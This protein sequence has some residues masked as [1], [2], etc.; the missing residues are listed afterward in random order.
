MCNGAATKLGGR[1]LEIVLFF[2]I[3]VLVYYSIQYIRLKGEI[4]SRSIKL[5]EEWKERE[6]KTI[7]ARYNEEI[8]RLKRLYVEELER[9]K[10][11]Y[12]ELA[13]RTAKNLF[14]TWKKKEEERIRKEAVEKSTSVIKGKVTEHLVPFFPEFKYNPKDVRF[15]GSPIDLVIFQGL[16]EGRL[17]KIIFAEVKTGKSNLTARERVIRD[18][19]EKKNVTFEVIEV[20][21]VPNKIQLK[22]LVPESGINNFSGDEQNSKFSF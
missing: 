2:L 3:L 6:L 19:I 12:S 16:S 22:Y 21:R 10:K 1:M 11:N 15:I 9:M 4:E 20:P 7:S 13:E 5:Y 8:E 18:C 14:E 17:E